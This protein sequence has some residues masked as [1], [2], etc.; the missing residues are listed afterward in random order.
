MYSHNLCFFRMVFKRDSV[1][2]IFVTFLVHLL[3]FLPRLMKIED[4]QTCQT[5][6]AFLTFEF[7]FIYIKKTSETMRKNISPQIINRA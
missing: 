1:K 3:T 7:S 4:Q 5:S 6:L 2:I